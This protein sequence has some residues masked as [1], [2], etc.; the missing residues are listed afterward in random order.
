MEVLIDTS[1]GERS[2]PEWS[3]HLLRTDEGSRIDLA[4][5]RDL[6]DAYLRTF[7]PDAAGFASILRALVG[8]SP[9]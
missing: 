1:A 4:A 6:R 3:M 9:R 5:L 7:L 8:E 2:L